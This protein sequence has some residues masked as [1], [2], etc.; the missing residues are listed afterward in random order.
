MNFPF[1]FWKQTSSGGGTNYSFSDY[2]HPNNFSL[3]K[4]IVKNQI[5]SNQTSIG[6]DNVKILKFIVD[7]LLTVTDISST[8]VFDGTTSQ[9]YIVDYTYVDGIQAGN[10]PPPN[11]GDLGYSTYSFN[12]TIASSGSPVSA[13]EITF[14]RNDAF[15]ESY[16]DM[17][18][19]ILQIVP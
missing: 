7:R 9:N 16:I 4:I 1:S 5:T 19:N 17:S 3:T 15:S 18:V 13:G 6:L 14:L 10:P 11:A 2:S 8:D 12:V